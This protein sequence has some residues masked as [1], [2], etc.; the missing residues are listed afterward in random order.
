MSESVS[1][2]PTKSSHFAILHRLFRKATAFAHSSK[3]QTAAVSANPQMKSRASLK[4]EAVKLE[5]EE[6]G[7]DALRGARIMGG[8]LQ[9]F[10]FTASAKIEGSP[11]G[12]TAGMFLPLRY[13]V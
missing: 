5:A 8:K 10:S 4:K 3:P 1:Q 11:L 13:S 6:E 2:N 7:T 12:P 9:G